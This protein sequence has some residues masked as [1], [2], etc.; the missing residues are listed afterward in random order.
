[1]S[2][3]TYHI[4][5]EQ[6]AT[7]GLTLTYTDS[8]DSAIDLTGFV[9]RMQ[10]RRNI[11]DST[12]LLE[13]TTENGGIT[14]GDTSGTVAISISASDTAN[15]AAVEGVYDLELVSN[16]VVTRL[17]EGTFVVSPEVTR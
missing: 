7:F 15:L 14:L 2:A 16:G 6:G 4:K 12:A 1:M 10:L 13:A 9:A 8:N 3:G 5:I 11:N 17:L